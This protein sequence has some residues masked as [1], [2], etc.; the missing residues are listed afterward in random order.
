MPKMGKLP[1]FWILTESRWVFFLRWQPLALMF[2]SPLL[3]DLFLQ[4]GLLP[5]EASYWCLRVSGE[6]C[7]FLTTPG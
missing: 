6:G 4:E 7:G 3:S 5:L 2:M 1:S